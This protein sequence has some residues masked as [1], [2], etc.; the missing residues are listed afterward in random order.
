MFVWPEPPSL[1]PCVRRCASRFTGPGEGG[2]SNGKERVAARR[3]TD[4]YVAEGRLYAALYIYAGANTAQRH[5]NTRFLNANPCHVVLAGCV[6]SSCHASLPNLFGC[7][8]LP[9]GG[10]T[11]DVLF[12]GA[13]L[14]ALPPLE[15]ARSSLSFYVYGIVL[16]SVLP[17]LL[18]KFVYALFP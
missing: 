10:R 2:Q 1:R 3:A 9:E 17:C 12:P 6:Q 18:D 5:L 11:H 14:R 16:F 8:M 15:I 4:L 13:H 7:A